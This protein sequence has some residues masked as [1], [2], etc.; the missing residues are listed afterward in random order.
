MGTPKDKY[1]G[2]EDENI[3]A[4]KNDFFNSIKEMLVNMYEPVAKA[5]ADTVMLSTAEIF[6]SLQDFF[7]SKLYKQ[8]DVAIWL[9]NQGFKFI[10]IGQ[11]EIRLRWVMNIK[12]K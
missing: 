2:T 8:E 6:Y 7:H 3:K 9:H 4:I 5:N 10:N 12:A 1:T 11:G